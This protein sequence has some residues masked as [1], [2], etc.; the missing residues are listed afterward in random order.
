MVQQRVFISYRTQEPDISLAQ[1]FYDHLKA[2]GHNPFMAS[3]S[4]S[5]GENWV[6]RIDQELKSCD[7]FLLLLSEKSVT[8]DMV[9]GEVRTAK[10][11]LDDL[12]KPIIL[13][14]RLNLSHDDPLNY[15]LRS[16]LEKIQQKSWNS[17]EDTAKL[18]KEILALI[19]GEL[20]LE[21]VE[22][23]VTPVAT[24]EAKNR[25]PLPVA[26]L[27]LPG[28]TMRLD[29]EF[30]IKR[31]PLESR[32][33]QEIENPAGLVR[34]RAPR[35][36]GKTS[37]LARI[38]DRAKDLGYRTVT[39]DFL[40][41]DERALSDSSLFLKRFCALVS[42]KLDISPRNVKECWDED[43]FGAQENCTSYFEEYILSELNAPLLLALDEIDL[44]FPYQSVSETFLSLLRSWNED[45]KVSDQ[46]AQLRV[47]ISYSTESYV[48]LPINRSPFNVGL[49]VDRP[50]FTPEQVQ[51][52]AERHNLK[53]NTE[54][55]NTLMEMI[56]GHP[57]LV[58]LSLYKIA[59]RDLTLSKIIKEAPTDG[60][61][62]GEHLRRHLWNLQ[63]HPDLAI[64]FKKV[65]DSDYPV[66]L[67]SI[68]AKKLDGMGLVHMQGDKV[69][70]RHES[71]YRPYFRLRLKVKS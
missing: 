46:W 36:M 5:W 20:E 57:Y 18:Q 28:G 27:E 32:C 48:V 33:L 42:Q 50:E 22:D 40:R 26:D 30:Y 38:R 23:T 24:T 62:Y 13:P 21:P 71:M 17:E 34:I 1:E 15:E 43:L 7:Y 44:I 16:S 64:A 61:I 37:L 39:I 49:A 53:W 11:L 54:E 41:T 25:P 47:A 66:V 55:I 9:S 45:G 2:S 52:L 51:E 58:G 63:Q 29:S 10:K 4:I 60:G 70:L 68:L 8:S 59:Q 12:G 19:E 56:G 69:I 31:E 35:Q 3:K 65:I 67:K 6:E 14:I